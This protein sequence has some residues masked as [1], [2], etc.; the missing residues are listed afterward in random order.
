ME[1]ITLEKHA[2][3]HAKGFPKCINDSKKVVEAYK[4]TSFI[5]GFK[6]AEEVMYTEEEVLDLLC[7]RNIE[8]NIYEGRENIEQWFE[9][10]K[11]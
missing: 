5:S 7:A 6:K 2:E 8:L 1:K 9:Q 3:K 11:K 10:F 4:R